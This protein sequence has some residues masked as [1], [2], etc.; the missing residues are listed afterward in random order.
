MI[1][2]IIEHRCTGQKNLNHTHIATESLF[3][4]D[5]YDYLEY[6]GGNP[7]PI[8]YQSYVKPNISPHVTMSGDFTPNTGVLYDTNDDEDYN[9]VI[10]IDYDGYTPPPSSGGSSGSGS[11]GTGGG[12]SDPVEDPDD[13][14]PDTTTPSTATIR[15]FFKSTGDPADYNSGYTNVVNGTSVSAVTI[16][17]YGMTL[18]A[19][20]TYVKTLN[21]YK[22]DNG[23]IVTKNYDI[24]SPVG[25][26]L[27]YN[28]VSTPELSSHEEYIKADYDI[29]VYCF[30]APT[31]TVAYTSTPDT[32]FGD[33]PATINVQP[34]A[35][36]HVGSFAADWG[37]IGGMTVTTKV[38]VKS[39]YIFKQ[40]DIKIGNTTTVNYG[41]G[42]YKEYRYT[43]DKFDDVTIT[44]NFERLPAV[45]TQIYPVGTGTTTPAAGTITPTDANY[46]ITL[47][48]T[49]N[50]GYVFK[51]WSKNGTNLSE[52]DSYTYKASKGENVIITAN[53]EKIPDPNSEDVEVPTGYEN[54]MITNNELEE[55]SLYVFNKNGL[56]GSKCPTYG[57]ISNANYNYNII[58]VN[59]SYG[60]NQCVK[61]SDITISG[62]NAKITV[63]N[64]TTWGFKCPV[65]YLGVKNDDT[66]SYHSN[67][68]YNGAVLSLNDRTFTIPISCNASSGNWYSNSGDNKLYVK[69]DGSEWDSNRR[70]EIEINGTKYSSGAEHKIE[71]QS[72]IN[73][74][75]F[76]RNNYII[77]VWVYPT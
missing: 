68:T 28:I 9:I 49:P 39:G 38:N 62:I 73:L 31:I 72:T 54:K 30:K 16:S 40:W 37:M 71:E 47:N 69:V 76:L 8:I 21:Y 70:I 36:G 14:D 55:V 41:S 6:D 20:Q 34:N 4:Y 29:K 23:T 19:G 18:V 59:N 2:V 64:R 26:Y 17:H 44:A 35:Y 1:T 3:I 42:T 56:D 51:N 12:T 50:D 11:S 46:Q 13:I 24:T 65:I 43:V 5:S 58:S 77:K 57:H 60:T 66:V 22:N 52:Y 33:P 75:T 61:Y 7:R 45:T 10:H 15:Y 48:A 53:F 67:G 74:N 32:L 63:Y 27:L 25:G